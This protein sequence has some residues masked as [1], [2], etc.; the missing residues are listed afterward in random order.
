MQELYDQYRHSMIHKV[1][2]HGYLNIIIL[3]LKRTGEKPE[4]FIAAIATLFHLACKQNK[5]VVVRLLINYGV[6]VN[7]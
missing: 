4:L 2:S 5:V 6:D 7:F 1:T 3:Y